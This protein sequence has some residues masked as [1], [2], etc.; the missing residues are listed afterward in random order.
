MFVDI[1]FV[2]N[3]RVGS[4]DARRALEGFDSLFR[5]F[6]GLVVMW[7]DRKAVV[8][9]MEELFGDERLRA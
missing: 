1:F 4:D 9:D 5:I 8:E 6:V 3:S 2:D 7:R